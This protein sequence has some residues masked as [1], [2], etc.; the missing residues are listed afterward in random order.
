MTN[1]SLFES[2]WSNFVNF[3]L[4][5]AVFCRKYAEPKLLMETYEI[6]EKLFS[7]I[8]NHYQPNVC[9]CSKKPTFSYVIDDERIEYHSNVIT[10]R[11]ESAKESSTILHKSADMFEEFLQLVDDDKKHKNKEIQSIVFYMPALHITT[12]N[13][14]IQYY[15]RFIALHQK[16]KMT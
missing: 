4:N 3:R 2:I 12:M 8:E 6:N 14:T 10:Q 16:I 7:L 15:M 5:D 1:M 9:M 11:L 13:S